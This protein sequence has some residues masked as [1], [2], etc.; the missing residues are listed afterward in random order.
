MESNLQVI[1]ANVK[2]STNAEYETEKKTTQE[3]E[4]G[5][6]TMYLGGPKK[7]LKPWYSN[8]DLKSV[9]ERNRTQE[10]KLDAA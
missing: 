5:K 6:M 10:Q 9:D 1:P 8:P 2:F 4:E 7:D 3:K